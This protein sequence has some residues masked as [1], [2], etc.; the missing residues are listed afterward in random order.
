LILIHE[1]GHFF[2]A[3]KSGVGVRE[4]ALGFGPA[5]FAWQDKKSGTQYRLNLVPLGGYCAMIGEDGV[6]RQNDVDIQGTTFLAVG[7]WRRLAIVAAGPAVNLIAAFLIIAFSA[8]LVGADNG[9]GT[10]HV[11]HMIAGDPAE[12]A[13]LRT[14]DTITS[15]DGVS[16]HDGAAMV[17]RINGS[18]GKTLT[19]VFTRNDVAQTI[20]VRPIPMER[21]GKKV[22]IIGFSPMALYERE[23]P[24]TAFHNAGLEMAGMISATFEGFGQLFHGQREALNSVSGPIGIARA[25]VSVQD[26]GPGLYLQFV[27]LLSVSLGI[28]NLLPFPAL[29][30]GRAIFVILELLRGKP[31]DPDR[32]AMVHLTGF[33]A[34][35]VLVLIVSYHD[36]VNI[37][38]GVASF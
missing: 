30:G 31:V 15:I 29:D 3:R 17:Q 25:A 38:T 22:G 37:A 7:P 21:Q 8:M 14:G 2:I 34:L 18:L 19:I 33:A 4:F 1:W 13:G 24:I 10:T 11:G 20:H 9:K 23:D 32:E 35:I 16:V 27:A 36:I 6:T 26:Y 28:F 12:K 5:L